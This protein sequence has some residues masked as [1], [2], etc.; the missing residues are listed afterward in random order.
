[1]VAGKVEIDSLSYQE[2]AEPAKWICDGST[3]FE[4]KVG[5]RKTRGTTI[6]LHINE[7]SEEFLEESR[8]PKCS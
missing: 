1:M 8:I 7:D 6:T 3:E 4:I 5:K 2:G